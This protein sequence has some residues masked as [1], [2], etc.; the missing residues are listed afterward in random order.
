MDFYSFPRIDL[1]EIFSQTP[2]MIWEK[3]LEGFWLSIGFLPLGIFLVWLSWVLPKWIPMDWLKKFGDDMVEDMTESFEENE[4]EKAPPEAASIVSLKLVS[5]ENLTEGLG[6]LQSA[7]DKPMEDVEVI[8]DVYRGEEL[9][10]HS[11]AFISELG[12][13]EKVGFTL[14]FNLLENVPDTSALDLRAKISGAW[15]GG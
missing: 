14:Y 3:I 6:L 9:V 13:R 8:C 15:F 7:S 11:T 1:G 5:R 12:P 10:D 4:R 2:V